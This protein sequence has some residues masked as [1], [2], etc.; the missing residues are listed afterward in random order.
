MDGLQSS[1]DEDAA[2]QQQSYYE[3]MSSASSEYVIT[4]GDYETLHYDTKRECANDA[5]TY[6]SLDF[7]QSEYED[8][9]C[10]VSNSVY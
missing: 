7:T 9:T 1:V 8:A 5:P 2:T 10:T 4:T 3:N 6:A